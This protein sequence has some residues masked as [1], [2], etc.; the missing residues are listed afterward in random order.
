MRGALAALLGLEDDVEVVAEV[1]RGDEVVAAAHATH[2][3]VALLDIE[4]PGANGLDVTARLVAELPPCRVV[5]LTTF[6]RTGYL[7]RA[8]ENGASG[9]LLKDAPATD[10]A[11]ALRRVLAGS[12]WSTPRSR[13]RR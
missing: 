2:P 6:G 3:D 9:F 10:L 11:R 1:S 7:R 5:V 4:M 12:G 8:M 13:R